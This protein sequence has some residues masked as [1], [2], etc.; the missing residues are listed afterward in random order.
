MSVPAA[1]RL[2]YKFGVEINALDFLVA[3]AEAPV[4]DCPSGWAAAVVLLGIVCKFKPGDPVLEALALELSVT[5]ER[6]V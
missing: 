2:Q 1:K 5:E 6:V 4:V 3:D